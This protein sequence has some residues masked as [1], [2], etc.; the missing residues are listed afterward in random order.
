MGF[1]FS[2]IWVRDGSVLSL[3][4]A[5]AQRWPGCGNS[6]E[7]G[8]SLKLSVVWD[9]LSGEAPRLHLHSGREHDARV[10][11][12]KHPQE[13]P[14]AAGEMHLFDLGYFCLQAMS[15]LHQNGAFFCCRYKSGTSVRRLEDGMEDT[16][17]SSMAQRLSKLSTEITQ[18]DWQVEIGQRHPLPVRLIGR[19]VPPQIAL[20]RRE[21]L[22]HRS[23]RKGQPAGAERLALCDWNLFVTNAPA[24]RLHA[25]AVPRLYSARWQIER[26]FRLWKENLR[27]DEWRTKSPQRIECEIYAKL[28]G[29]LLAQRIC[30]WA[31]W[32]DPARSILQLTQAL[33]AWALSL[34]THL[35]RKTQLKRVLMDFKKTTNTGCKLQ[36]R[37]NKP[38]TFQILIQ[39]Q[40]SLA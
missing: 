24:E 18:F 30:A 36:R 3:P 32:V 20:Q 6:T 23:R 14:P 11:L 10:G 34:G 2:R 26:L 12:G 17:S 15:D 38:A 40:E 9:W 5:L 22:L 37:R 16:F 8:A 35:H 13:P 31:A 39:E 27:I 21:N 4:R 7:T 33:Q 25:E 29:A 28:I 19:R 1:G